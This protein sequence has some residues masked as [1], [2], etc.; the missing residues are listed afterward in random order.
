M[1]AWKP[2]QMPSIRPSRLLSRFMIASM[3]RGLRSAV[4]I[5]LPEPSGSSPAEKPPGSITICARLMPSASASMDSSMPLAVRLRKT[6]TSVSAPAR[7]NAF[8]LS[9]SQFVPGKDG[10]N[11]R[12]LAI[13]IFGHAVLRVS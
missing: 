8:S 13:W 7:R 10:I 3:M 2:L 11:T 6:N 5:N 4:A 9:S 1:S 12:G